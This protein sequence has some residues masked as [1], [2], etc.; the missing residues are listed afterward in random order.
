MKTARLSSPGI[1]ALVGTLLLLPACDAGSPSASTREARVRILLTDN[2]TDYLSEARVQIS[3]VYL[4]R[5][6]EDPE[7]GPPFVDLFNDPDNPLEYDL[8]ELRDGVV[9]DMTGEVEIPAGRYNQLRMIVAHAEVELAPGHTFADGST[10]R[11][12]FIP[13]GARTGIKVNLARAVDAEAR[14]LTTVL[15]DFDV[16][17]NFVIQGNPNSPAG[18]IGILFTPVLKELSRTEEDG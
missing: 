15:V 14:S 4:I 2:P 1:L 9:A 3:R 13:S 18:I 11:T 17:R 16:D 12:L 6:D 10:H 8:L 7:Q 5:G